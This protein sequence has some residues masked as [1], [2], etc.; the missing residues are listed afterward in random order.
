[1]RVHIDLIS[2]QALT[3]VYFFE[4][5]AK[6]RRLGRKVLPMATAVE[7]LGS[8]DRTL[9]LSGHPQR[10]KFSLLDLLALAPDIIAFNLIL[11]TRP[12]IA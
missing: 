11:M 4:I 3:E 5:D 8:A 1:L 9:R 6:A 12:H 10:Q 2:I 7:K